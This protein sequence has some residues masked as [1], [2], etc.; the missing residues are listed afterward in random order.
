MM[1]ET[2][3]QRMNKRLAQMQRDRAT[4]EAHW[5][6][7]S[8][9]FAPRL[10]TNIKTKTSEPSGEKRH[11]K[12]INGKPL[13]AVRTL[14]AGMMSGNTSPAR[15]WFRLTTPDPQLAEF[16]PVK[17]WLWTVE[18]RMREVLQKSNLYRQLSKVYRDIGI[19]GPSCLVG[20][21]DSERIV[22]WI[23]WEIGTYYLAESARGRV[24]TAYREF[25]MTIRQIVQEFG[26]ENVS[27]RIRN[28]FENGQ[29]E[30][31]DDICHAIEP[32]GEQWRSV[33]WERGNKEQLLAD[34]YF[35]TNPIVAPRWD[36]D[37]AG[38]YGYSPAMD[39]LG[40]ALALQRKEL[41][42]QEAIDIVVKP[43]L[44]GPT[45][46]RNTTVSMIP[47]RITYVDIAAGQQGIKSIHDWRPEIAPMLEDIAKTEQL[48]DS[49]LFVDLFRMLENLD[50]RDITAFE[51]DKR[52]KERMLLL[53]PVIERL[54]DELNSAVID[55]TFDLMVDV[56]KPFW[57]GA[58]DG[59][60]LIPMP[61]EE[62]AGME[63]KVEFISI[64]SQAQKAVGLGA[65]D[66]LLAFVANAAQMK[67]DVLDK[68]DL[69]QAVDERAD[70]LGV[71]PKIVVPDDK[72]AA[73][74]Q[75]RARMQQAQMAAQAA[76]VASQS[77]K[78]LSQADMT[79]DN[80]LTRAMGIVG[81]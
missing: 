61:P 74:R 64:L 23:H 1:Q 26:I 6:D 80:A 52:E 59:N 51:I 77:A 54:N 35:R 66:N 10:A 79:G 12:I 20:V 55:R 3:C 5:R 32:N 69:D 48:I 2:L 43:P 8:E 76:Q 78:D 24:D 75:E 62:L 37:G 34:R 36:V 28:M 56:S 60:P 81:A 65:A 27:G 71:S 30:T 73:I 18:T 22:H 31:W 16:G 46:L 11:Q 72:V 40:D 50:R 4:Y 14:A 13:Q 57:S 53:G 7:L 45:S 58:L 19:F 29:F 9:M 33:Y 15:P 49:A 21:P 63:L 47:G 38:V 17:E 67:P 39:A 42:K 25:K 44:M 68:I 70:M 41:R